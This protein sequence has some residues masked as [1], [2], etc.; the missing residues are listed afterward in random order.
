MD[1][2]AGILTTGG[3]ARIL[4]VHG[5]TVRRWRKAGK[6]FGQAADNG[7][8]LYLRSEVEQLAAE[9]AQAKAGR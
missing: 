7:T 6:L 3:A 5:A 9:R 8:V 4:G 2:Q 1:H